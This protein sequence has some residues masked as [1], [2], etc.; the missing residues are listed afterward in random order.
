M[1]VNVVPAHY[2]DPAGIQNLHIYSG[3]CWQGSMFKHLMGDKSESYLKSVL[4]Q[5][6]LKNGF[7]TT[8]AQ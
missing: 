1:K 6:R 2:W 7:T 8:P 5:N 4:K 3:S